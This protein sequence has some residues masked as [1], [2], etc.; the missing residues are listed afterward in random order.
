MMVMGEEPTAC[1]TPRQLLSTHIA[2]AP[3]LVARR[4]KPPERRLLTLFVSLVVLL[5]RAVDVAD[6]VVAD[7]VAAELA[8]VVFEV[9]LDRAASFALEAFEAVRAVMVVRHGS[10]GPQ[11]EY[12]A[13]G[14]D[15]PCSLIFFATKTRPHSFEQTSQAPT[16]DS[17]RQLRFDS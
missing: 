14:S 4:Q 6:D 3:P 10:E 1:Q 12:T 13:V 7:G 11:T 16:S 17:S 5:D 15:V 8:T 9:R 2:S